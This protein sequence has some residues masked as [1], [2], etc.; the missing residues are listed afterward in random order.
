MVAEVNPPDNS[1][2]NESE[3]TPIQNEPVKV[4]TVEGMEIKNLLF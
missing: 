3:Q 4:F 2:K 1:E